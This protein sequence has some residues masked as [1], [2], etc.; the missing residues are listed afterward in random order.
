MQHGFTLKLPNAFKDTAS[1]IV[2]ISFFGLV[3]EHCDG[4]PI[5][6][7][8]LSEIIFSPG[9]TPPT[10]P[11]LRPFWEQAKAQHPCLHRMI[12]QISC[13]YAV[14]PNGDGYTQFY[15]DG[16]QPHDWA[17]TLGRCHLGGT[18]FPI[19]HPPAMGG[20][21]I[22]FEEYFGNFNFGSGNAQLDLRTFS[23]D[24]AC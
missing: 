1:D 22:E 23:F 20:R 9:N 19:Q 8:G 10:D 2:A 13:H 4:M 18:M 17:K 12:D 24:W 15:D 7:A 21:Y 11:E 16:F 6:T 14:I 5:S 3:P